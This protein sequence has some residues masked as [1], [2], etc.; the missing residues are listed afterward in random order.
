[1]PLF[2]R[3]ANTGYRRSHSNEQCHHVA[4]ILHFVGFRRQMCG[5]Q[6]HRRPERDKFKPQMAIAAAQSGIIVVCRLGE[7][8]ATGSGY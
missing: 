8:I 3:V 7:P 4:Q 6:G 5:G 1:M 2:T